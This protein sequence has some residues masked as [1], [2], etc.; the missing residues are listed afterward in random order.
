MKKQKKLTKQQRINEL[1]WKIV[2]KILKDEKIP[3][4]LE[5][6]LS[7]CLYKIE[8]EWLIL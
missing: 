8:K 2:E 6:A 5:V 1:A 7:I 4:D 3:E